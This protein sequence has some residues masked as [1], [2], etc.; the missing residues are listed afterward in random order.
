M[1][2]EVI[3]RSLGQ[4]SGLLSEAVA[5]GNRAVGAVAFAGVAAS[6]PHLFDGWFGHA[7]LPPYW[8]S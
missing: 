4:V 5:G 1:G 8:S 7:F 2:S 3:L 6:R